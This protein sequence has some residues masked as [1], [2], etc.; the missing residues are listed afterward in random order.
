[1]QERNITSFVICLNQ[2]NN[3]LLIKNKKTYKNN[4]LLLCFGR[5]GACICV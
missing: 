3:Q 4:V 1:M 2:K 5:F